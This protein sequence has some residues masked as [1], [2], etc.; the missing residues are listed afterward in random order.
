MPY[1]ECLGYRIG[2]YKLPEQE[3]VALHLP[4]QEGFDLEE[5]LWR[6]I[7]GDQE[8]GPEP[9]YRL[10]RPA[11]RFELIAFYI[12]LDDSGFGA[13]LQDETVDIDDL[14]FFTAFLGCTDIASAAI[15]GYA[16]DGSFLSDTSPNRDDIVQPAILDRCEKP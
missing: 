14:N 5:V 13:A 1:Q 7:H 6:M 2:N 10:E 8:D 16:R 3:R 4:L 9:F 15:R 11:D 12:H